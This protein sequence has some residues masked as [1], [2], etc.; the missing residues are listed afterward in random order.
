ME[1]ILKFSSCILFFLFLQQGFS[2]KDKEKI[3]ANFDYVEY[4][5][6]STIKE[7]RKFNGTHLEGT[8]VE[9]NTTGKPVAIGE[10]KKG[11]KTG[12]WLYSDGSQSYFISYKIQGR[13]IRLNEN[14]DEN[15]NK[16]GEIKT[17]EQSISTFEFHTIY[18]KLLNPYKVQKICN[19][20]ISVPNTDPT[21]L[22]FQLIIK[23]GNMRPGCGTGIYTAIQEFRKK[24]EELLNP[25]D[26]HK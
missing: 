3:L 17:R 8:T 25:I 20:M 23:T 13:G 14:P 6:D 15:G 7:A 19:M 22:P 9:F 5:P 12:K 21:T 16:T 11:I 10:Y 1:T 26:V 24:Y 4:Y 18:Q 2:Q